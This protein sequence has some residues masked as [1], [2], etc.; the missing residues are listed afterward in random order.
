MRKVEIKRGNKEVSVYLGIVDQNG[1]YDV[2]TM[3]EGE[4]ALVYLELK[5]IL[6]Q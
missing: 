6:N 3:T 5:R 2:F 1:E 4:A